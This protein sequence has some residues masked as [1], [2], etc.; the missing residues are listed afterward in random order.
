LKELISDKKIAFGDNSIEV[1]FK[2][3]YST[4][5]LLSS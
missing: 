2:L 4:Y 5:M 3:E 1:C